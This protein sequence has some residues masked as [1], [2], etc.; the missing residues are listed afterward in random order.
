M[1]EQI[2]IDWVPRWD[3]NHRPV[4]SALQ[5]WS[6]KFLEAMDCLGRSARV[7][8]DTSQMM[9]GAQ[10]KVEFRSVK[11]YLNP[12]SPDANERKIAKWFNLGFCKGLE[13]MSLMP[14]VEGIGMTVD[15]VHDLCE[16][17]RLE[18]RDL[19]HHPYFALYVLSPTDLGC[20]ST[21]PLCLFSAPH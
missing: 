13:G 17:V 11:C 21:T 9:N 6:D 5:E 2:E 14:M 7:W 15:H 19:R 18:L 16:R 20:A 3:G 4:Q 10:L 12:W 1:L 8:S